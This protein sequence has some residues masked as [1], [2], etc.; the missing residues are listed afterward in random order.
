MLC[1][2]YY[3]T[4]PEL[5]LNQVNGKKR[6]YAFL[7][8]VAKSM[9][10]MKQKVLIS[11][12]MMVHAFWLVLWYF[13]CTL[14]VT[15]LKILGQ[16]SLHLKQETS[17]GYIYKFEYKASLYLKIKQVVREELCIWVGKVCLLTEKHKFSSKL[18]ACGILS[19]C[20]NL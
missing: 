16:M 10:L 12:A 6:A 4:S 13:L 11:I 1:D 20:L 3:L 7:V 18:P 5:K 9:S 14:L 15:S 2:Q 17:W 19:R 8:I